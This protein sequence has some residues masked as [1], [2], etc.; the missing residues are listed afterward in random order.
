MN[1]FL[2]LLIT[3]TTYGTWLPGDSRGWRRQTTGH[4]LPQPLLEQW[5]R[6]QMSGEVV[7]L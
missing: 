3:W 2:H 7:L 1:D 6:A 4:Q 5:C